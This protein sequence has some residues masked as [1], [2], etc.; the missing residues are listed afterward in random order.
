MSLSIIVASSNG[1]LVAAERR[2]GSYVH[3]IL[4]DAEKFKHFPSGMIFF[5]GNKKVTVYEGPHNFVAF[6]YTG[7]GSINSHQLIED[8]RIELPASRLR[9]KEYADALIQVYSRNPDAYRFG[10]NPFSPEDS[11]CI[12]VTGY[13]VGSASAF[14]YLIDLP[15]KPGPAQMGMHPGGMMVSGVGDHLEDAIKIWKAK[16]IK[17][18]ESQI[19]G[20]RL[21][22]MPTVTHE[23]KLRLLQHSDI[24]WKGMLLQEMQEFA[25]FTIQYTVDQQ[26]LLNEEPTVGG[27]TD[28][29]RIT[30][31]HGVETVNYEPFFGI[32]KRPLAQTHHNYVVL[33]C[34]GRDVEIQID[35]ELD[36]PLA[37]SRI[38][39]PPDEKFQCSQCKTIHDL[40]ELRSFFQ[41]LVNCYVILD[42]KI[43]GQSPE[44]FA[45]G[46]A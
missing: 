13:D 14:L 28:V 39:Y 46:D 41:R 43:D 21:V 22:G 44:E 17:K 11:N 18:L 1:I 35:F 7:S 38:R 25:E 8:L 9:I 5:D 33:S 30:K 42:G 12:Y 20:A 40:T 27:G 24:P 26:A 10:E 15:F 19:A 45:K 31:Q 23:A 6:T 4:V 29:I 16:Q 3:P 37:K 34:C 2:V 36:N 32:G